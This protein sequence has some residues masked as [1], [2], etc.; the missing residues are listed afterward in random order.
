ME[1]QAALLTLS[2]GLDQLSRITLPSSGSDAL[3]FLLA[4]RLTADQPGGALAAWRK[5]DDS[6]QLLC[7]K[8]SAAS[9]ALLP[10]FCTCAFAARHGFTWPLRQLR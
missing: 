10:V 9:S 2:I 6:V 1:Q 7:A 4:A 5:S 3:S 8:V